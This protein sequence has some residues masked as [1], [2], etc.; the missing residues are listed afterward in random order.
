[1]LFHS[2]TS[3][4]PANNRPSAHV[5]PRP[6]WTIHVLWPWLGWG[7]GF[8]LPSAR[9]VKGRHLGVMRVRVM[10]LDS[11]KCW[12]MSVHSRDRMYQLL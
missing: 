9:A 4:L 2:V 3:A 1:M 12:R 7:V 5:W 11:Q 8:Q 6:G 10:V